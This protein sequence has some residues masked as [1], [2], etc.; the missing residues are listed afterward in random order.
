MKLS[1]NVYRM[2][3][4]G[5]L[6]I[7]SRSIAQIIHPGSTADAVAAYS[8]VDPEQGI[9]FY[10]FACADFDKAE[11]LEKA[12]DPRIVSYNSLRFEE[13]KLDFRYSD[14]QK[15]LMREAEKTI[16]C[17]IGSNTEK[18]IVRRIGSLDPF[19]REYHPDLLDI[20]DEDGCL[21][22][23]RTVSRQGNI[24]KTEETDSGRTVYLQCVSTDEVRILKKEDIYAFPL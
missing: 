2:Y 5:F 21:L 15:Q 19:R 1:D 12:S 4:D 11:M 3:T 22:H 10:C 18:A 20:K 6:M 17:S 8:F 14:E 24:V 16:Q 9:R 13:A 7:K 23:L